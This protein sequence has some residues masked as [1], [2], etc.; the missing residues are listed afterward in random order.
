MNRRAVTATLLAAG[1]TCLGLGANSAFAGLGPAEW[2]IHLAATG[3]GQISAGWLSMRDSAFLLSTISRYETLT[4]V[5]DGN[6]AEF[7]G[8][9]GAC[10]PAGPS[11]CVVTPGG[12]ATGGVLAG[13]APCRWTAALFARPGE[14]TPVVVNPCAPDEGGAG[15]GA[16]GGAT[17][18]SGAASGGASGSS[19]GASGSGSGGAA[20][21][22]PVGT[23]LVGGVKVVSKAPPIKGARTGSKGGSVK[24]SGKVPE[25]TT[26]VV[27]SLV[28]AGQPGVAVA[29]R[30]R[31]ARAND[32]FTCSAT[33]PRGR[34]RV[35][36]QTR[37]GASVVGQASA[38]VTV[39]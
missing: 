30:C 13:G 14:P 8:W 21:L 10:E 35:V 34:W 38:I 5:P 1:A 39:R 23:G 4:P 16:G 18:G 3:P 31:I 27:Q 22:P 26:K 37:R 2:S 17:G 33:P 12:V 25:G 28:L 32:T 11:T 7:R 19:G 9:V 29:G 20:P 24:A 15:G 36:T 6:G